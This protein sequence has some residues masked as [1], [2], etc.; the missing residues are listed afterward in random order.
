[1][2]LGL[3]ILTGIFLLGTFQ[4]AKAQDCDGRLRMLMDD[5]QLGRFEESIAGINACIETNGYS[6]ASK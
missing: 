1:M 6:S 3:K 2:K 4:T 5:Y